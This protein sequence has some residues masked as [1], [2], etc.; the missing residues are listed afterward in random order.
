M[1]V[2]GVA[3]YFSE[4]LN[5]MELGHHLLFFFFAFQKA[6]DMNRALMPPDKGTGT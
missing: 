4:F 6:N 1:R 3:L 2:N 5:Y